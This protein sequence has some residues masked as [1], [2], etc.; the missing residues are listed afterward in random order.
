MKT[1]RQL[2]VID[3]QLPPALFNRLAAMLVATL[4]ALTSLVYAPTSVAAESQNSLTII[5]SYVD[6]WNT[7]D[8]A[9]LNEVLAPDVNYFNT[10]NESVRVGPQAISEVSNFLLSIL[11]DR[12]MTIQSRPVVNGNEV[13][14]EWEF[15]AT[16]KRRNSNAGS[17][18]RITFKGASFFR[19]KDG[20]IT[21]VGDYYNSQTMRQQL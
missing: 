10:S 15:T 17:A 8:S 14:F 1:N 6:A 4:V 9:R 21:Y 7:G 20:K 5:N 13:A 18:Q 3:T 11:P 12:K 19:V 2:L 16:K